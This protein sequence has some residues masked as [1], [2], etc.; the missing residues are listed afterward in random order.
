MRPEDYDLAVKALDLLRTFL[1]ILAVQGVC[2]C[3]ILMVGFL[4]VRDWLKAIY[5]ALPG[6]SLDD[7]REEFLRGERPPARTK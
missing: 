5:G 7:V 4:W 6:R 3:I 2:I 1:T